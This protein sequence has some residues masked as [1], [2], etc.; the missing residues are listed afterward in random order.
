MLSDQAAEILKAEWGKICSLA[1]SGKLRDW[2][3]ESN[4]LKAVHASV[5][6]STKTYRYVLPQILSK[7]ADPSLDS[8]CL[9][10]LRGGQGA[11]DARTVAHG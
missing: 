2:L 8:H 5:N 11:F 4:L 6:S 7:L 10:A 3:D 1:E 9:Q